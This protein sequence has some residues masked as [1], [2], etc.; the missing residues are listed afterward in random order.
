MRQR[1]ASA[2]ENAQ[3]SAMEPRTIGKQNRYCAEKAAPYHSAG[4][5]CPQLLPATMSEQLAL[6]GRP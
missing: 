3:A 5:H 4:W 6:M 1:P 2:I